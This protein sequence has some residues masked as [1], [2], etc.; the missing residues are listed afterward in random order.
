MQEIIMQAYASCFHAYY[1]QIYAGIS[2]RHKHNAC[3]YAS[4]IA[5]I[6]RAI[7]SSYTN[8]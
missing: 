5:Q 3:T 7:Y 1:A 2:N 6:D 8:E 4:T